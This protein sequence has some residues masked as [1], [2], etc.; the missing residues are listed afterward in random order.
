[1]ETINITKIKHGTKT[2]LEDEVASEEILSIYLNKKL[3]T[4]FSC[5]GS[6]INELIIG[7]LFFHKYISDYNEIT[8]FDYNIQHKSAY[9]SIEKMKSSTDIFSKS[10]PKLYAHSNLL[11]LMSNFS[12][13]SETFKKTGAVHSAG[14]ADEKAIIKTFDDLSRHNT[15]YMLLGYSLIN[16]IPLS[17]KI[18]LLTCRLTNSIMEIIQKT[19]TNIIVTKAAPT[20][21]AVK[22]CRERNI[23]LAGFVRENRMN[24]YNGDEC[25][26]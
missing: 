17:D 12:S 1:M 7:Y 22:I 19:N 5:L 20:D 15:L 3:I 26:S 4:N 13:A 24:I 18:L 6:N 10:E 21:L 25:I 16:N 23:T 14:I 2:Q 8:S 9:I 11:S